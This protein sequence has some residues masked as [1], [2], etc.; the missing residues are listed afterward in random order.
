MY[1]TAN[2]MEDKIKEIR[3]ENEALKKRL[4]KLQGK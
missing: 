1:V 4:K 2:A 3:A